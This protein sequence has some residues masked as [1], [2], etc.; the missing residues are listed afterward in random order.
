MVIIEILLFIGGIIF[1]WCGIDQV[2][3]T[4]IGVGVILLFIAFIMLPFIMDKKSDKNIELKSPEV[5]ES[6][7]VTPEPK[8]EAT[9]MPEIKWG[10]NWGSDEET[11]EAEEESKETKEV[12]EKKYMSN[13][14]FIMCAKSMCKRFKID[15]DEFYDIEKGVGIKVYTNELTGVTTIELIGKMRE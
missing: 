10:L 4:P 5:T 15:W 2:E 7:Q 1:I 14:E 13:D 9:K 11:E 3:D 6:S 12:G 8:E